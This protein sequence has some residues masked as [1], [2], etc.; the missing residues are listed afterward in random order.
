MAENRTTIKLSTT[1]TDQDTQTK[2]HFNIS[3]YIFK[4]G[5]SYISYCPSLELSS[6]GKNIEE[7][8]KNFYECFQLH[9]ECCAEMGTLFDD[10]RDHGWKISKGKIIPPTLIEMIKKEKVTNILDGHLNYNHINAP[11]QLQ[12]A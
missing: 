12:F 3:F 10:F 1:A 9:I 5:D 2:Y 4:D 8:I 6:S 7:A 11:Y